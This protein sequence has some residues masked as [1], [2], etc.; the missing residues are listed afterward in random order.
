M[1]PNRAVLVLRCLLV[2][3]DLMT[4]LAL[5]AVFMPTAWMDHYHRGLELGPLPEGPIVQY[6]ARSVSA[7][8]AAFGSL[9]LLL[10]WDIR[11]FGPIIV[12]WGV[13]ALVFGSILFWVDTIAPMPRQWKWGETTYLW[14][15]GVVVL[16]LSWQRAQGDRSVSAAAERARN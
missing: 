15:T 3:N 6:L 8:Y 11:R 9:T 13:T 14:L 2:F 1:K 10:A 7:L 12:W 4:L 5:P 16:V